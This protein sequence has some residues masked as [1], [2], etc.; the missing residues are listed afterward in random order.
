MKLSLSVGQVETQETGSVAFIHGRFGGVGQTADGI[1]RVVTTHAVHQQVDLV[2]G[3][4]GIFFDAD[5]FSVYLQT[6]EPLLHVHVNL[7]GYGTSFARKNRSE[8]GVAGSFRI[9]EHAM[10]DILRAVF[11]YQLSA[12]GRIGF[13]DTGKQQAQILVDFGGGSDGGTRVP[14]HYLLFD[15]NGG[16]NA[17]DKVTFGFA[18]SS[19]ELAGIRGK[20]FHI[21][22]LSFG[23]ERVERQRG[24]PRA[25]QSGDN[26][27]L[28]ARDIYVNVFQ[29][30]DFSSFDGYIVTFSH[31]R[32]SFR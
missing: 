22:P 15:G 4:I 25:R 2:I 6:G 17:F 31:V 7:F 29:V 28:V 14:A 20:A 18:H 24:F 1:L 23:I 16:R 27:Q 26:H 3:L 19:E 5:H 12:Y 21:A 8:Y 9:G 10:D 32:F 11:L 30:V 13:S